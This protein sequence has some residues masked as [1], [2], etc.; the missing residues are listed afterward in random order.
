MFPVVKH[1]SFDGSK[2]RILVYVD[3]EYNDPYLRNVYNVYFSERY[4]EI[5]SKVHQDVTRV[6]PMPTYGIFQ[7]H[8]LPI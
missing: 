7:S 2:L 8:C 6:K 3:L 1:V 5:I 4:Y